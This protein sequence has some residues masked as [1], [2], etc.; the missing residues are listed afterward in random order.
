MTAIDVTRTHPSVTGIAAAVV[1]SAVGTAV[2]A[3]RPALVVLVGRPITLLVAIF[4]TLAVVGLVVPLREVEGS[5]SLRV[6]PVVTTGILAI[7]IARLVGE[8]RA[9]GPLTTRTVA[10]G[11][12]A[13]ASEEIWFRRL[14]FGLLRPAGPVAAVAAS[15]ALFGLVHVTIYGWWV[16]PIDIAAGLLL[17]WQREVTG[18]WHAPALTHAWAN[19]VVLL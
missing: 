14:L 7:T 11:V 6:V 9:P 17:G 1:V 13:A 19:V 5:P 15:A 2:F 3:A 18:S 10:L 16:L 8:G 4:V 12:L